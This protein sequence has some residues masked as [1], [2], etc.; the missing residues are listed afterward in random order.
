MYDFILRKAAHIVIFAVLTYFIA[1]SLD[2]YKRSYI[3]FIIFVVLAYAFV[4]E[5]HQAAII[6]RS[7]NSKDIL[8]DSVGIYLG[9][10]FYKDKV[11]EKIYKRIKKTSRRA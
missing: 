9:I 5:L 3:Y 4:D 7:G 1:K 2:Q 10:W 6:N 8:V 11:L